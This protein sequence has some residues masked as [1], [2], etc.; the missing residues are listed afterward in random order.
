MKGSVSSDPSDQ[1]G[2]ADLWVRVAVGSAPPPVLPRHLPFVTVIFC[3]G[4]ITS[5]F[6][7]LTCRY[8]LLLPILWTLG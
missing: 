8:V 2:I 4:V 5:R 1:W 7:M 3:Y 6:R